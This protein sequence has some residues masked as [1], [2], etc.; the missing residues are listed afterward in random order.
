M[1]ERPIIF[2]TEMVKAILDGRKTV[3]RRPVKNVPID[4]YDK[5]DKSYGPFTSDK[6]GDYHKTSE[7]CPF[8]QIGDRLYVRETIDINGYLDLYYRA[9]NEAVMNDM[10]DNWYYR[11]PDFVGS[12]SSIHMPKWAARIWLEITD[13]RVERVQDITEEGCHAEGI[14]WLDDRCYMDNGWQPTNNDPDSGGTPILK[15]AFEGNWNKRYNN[16]SDNPWTWVIEF[17]KLTPV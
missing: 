16:W 12:I 14:D 15:H 6:Y 9:D 3:T 8:G 7:Y 2:N 11:R 5:N 13:I 4:D 17:K 1:K 10:P